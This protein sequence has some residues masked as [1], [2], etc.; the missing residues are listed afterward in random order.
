MINAEGDIVH[1]ALLVETEPVT[2][3]EAMKSAK[4]IEAM[5]EELKSI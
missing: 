3:E 1:F 4:W 5:K 2:V